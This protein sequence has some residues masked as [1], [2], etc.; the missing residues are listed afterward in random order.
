MV[1][2]HGCLWE[3]LVEFDQRRVVTFLTWNTAGR[4]QLFDARYFPDSFERL[5]RAILNEVDELI[6]AV[7]ED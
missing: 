3:A 1:Q 6:D 4:W 5:L 7:L 2:M